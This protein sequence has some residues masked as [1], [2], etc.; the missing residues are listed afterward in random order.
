MVYFIITRK[1]K[2]EKNI[3]NLEY[4]KSIENGNRPDV[5]NIDN[6]YVIQLL[7][8]C[9]ATNPEDRISFDEI[10]DYIT[11]K[12]FYSYFQ[13]FDKNSVLEYLNIYGTE[14]DYLKSKF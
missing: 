2:L 13:L 5:S 9:W 12:E 8:K 1:I 6:K 3:R 4:F 14:F 7:N 10:I 11:N